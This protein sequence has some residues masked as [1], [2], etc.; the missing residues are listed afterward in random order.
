VGEARLVVVNDEVCV[1][2]GQSRVWGEV[3]VKH[4]RMRKRR[5]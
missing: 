2:L 3:E 4:R 1:A 5:S